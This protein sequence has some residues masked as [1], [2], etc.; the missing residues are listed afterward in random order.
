MADRPDGERRARFVAAVALAIP[1]RWTLVCEGVCEG[2]LGADGRGGR[3]FG[4]DPLF[5]PDGYDLSFG[6][7]L[8]EV[9]NI[10]SHRAKALDALL[11]LLR[12]ADF[13]NVRRTE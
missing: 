12:E 2:R 11:A 8:S 10:I 7:L 9:K 3:G 4:Y 13:E 6:E 1:G 5:V